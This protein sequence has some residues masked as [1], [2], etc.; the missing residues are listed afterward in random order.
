MSRFYI[1]KIPVD[2]LSMQ[3]AIEKIRGFLKNS[4]ETQPSQIVTVNSIMFNHTYGDAELLTAIE[5][6]PLVVPDSIGI[7]AAGY[8]LGAG[9]N[10]TAFS[11]IPGIDL[12][13]D[14]CRLAA[15]NKLSVFLLGAK[16]E[17]IPETAV[18]L[19]NRFPGL[20]ISGFSHGYFGEKGEKEVLKE[21]NS[22]K[23]DM[24]F[25]G[26]DV[27]RQE[28]WIYNNLKNISA[29][30]V[31]GVGGSFDVISGKLKRAPA[32][33][34]AAGLEWLYRVAQEPWR[35]TRIKDLPVFL[36]RIIKLRLG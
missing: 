14:M 18:A 12:M 4:S 31:M 34:R 11:R 28:K 15:E 35:I 19:K 2:F 26:L 17:V 29:K 3:A 24:L 36:I 22:K 21:I 33:M 9:R 13:M 20:N 27:P 25:V 23:P 7:V 1:G 10:G 8:I 6:S 32:F 30:I 16:P 5:K